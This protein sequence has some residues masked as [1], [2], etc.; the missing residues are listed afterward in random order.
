M[1]TFCKTKCI[2]S[3]GMLVLSFH[4][5]LAFQNCLL[6]WAETKGQTCFRKIKIIHVLHIKSSVAQKRT[7]VDTYVPSDA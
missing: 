3:R 5:V 7:L 4:A 1:N 6:G 2:N